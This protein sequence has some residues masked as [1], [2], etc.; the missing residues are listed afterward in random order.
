MRE[1]GTEAGCGH[2]QHQHNF[3]ISSYSTDLDHR[4]YLKEQINNILSRKATIQSLLLYLQVV[5]AAHRSLIKSVII[6]NM[7]SRYKPLT[8][9]KIHSYADMF[10]GFSRVELLSLE[11]VPHKTKLNMFLT[12]FILLCLYPVGAFKVSS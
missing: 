12:R 2:L 8:V 5:S 4:L 6:L 3:L 9:N 7:T 10:A 11:N 1:D